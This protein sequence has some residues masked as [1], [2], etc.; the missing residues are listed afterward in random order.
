MSRAVRKADVQIGMIVT[1]KEPVEAYYS[2]YPRGVTPTCFFEPGDR[3][4]VNALDVP[5]VWARNGQGRSFICVDFYKKGVIYNAAHG[6]SPWRVA[7]CYDN[8]VI[9]EPGPDDALRQKH[10]DWLLP[11]PH[12]KEEKQK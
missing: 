12:K 1:C 4:V 2:N 9:L 7:L 5:A 8:I 6:G 10:G 11:D 3:G